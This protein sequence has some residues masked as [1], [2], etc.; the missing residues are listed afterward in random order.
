[1][2]QVNISTLSIFG[3]EIKLTKQDNG[4]TSI[5][6]GSD[7]F[8]KGALIAMLGVDSADQAMKTLEESKGK[9]S[10]SHVHFDMLFGQWLKQIF[11]SQEGGLKEYA[12]MGLITITPVPGLFDKICQVDIQAHV[13]GV[14]SQGVHFV[15]PT[16]MLR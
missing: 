9:F 15:F 10:F 12:K 6:F 13:S 8:A 7:V 11:A 16:E 4:R 3:G 1:M 2:K 5:E 14:E